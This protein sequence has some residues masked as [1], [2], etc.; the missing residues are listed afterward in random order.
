M[1]PTC[2][3]SSFEIQPSR[4]TALSSSLPNVNHHNQQPLPWPSMSSSSPLTPFADLSSRRGITDSFVARSRGSNGGFANS[5][6]NISVMMANRSVGS[7]IKGMVET[8]RC[9]C[10][11]VEQEQLSQRA[12]PHAL[13]ECQTSKVL[14]PNKECYVVAHFSLDSY[15]RLVIMGCDGI[16][17]LMG[18][19]RAFWYDRDLMECCCIAMKNLLCSPC[20]GS[21]APPFNT[22]LGGFEA[23]GGVAAVI[24]A[25]KNHPQPVAVQSAARDALC[26]MGS[27]LL[28]H[29]ENSPQSEMATQIY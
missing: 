14:P 2:K 13:G 4:R 21:V 20:C 7:H 18:A 26:F 23:D 17:A 12:I 15:Y 19:M 1:N 27:L 11:E 5:I 6:H 3:P 28:Q 10:S 16:P 8:I 24:A 22:F 29:V 25:M 9:R